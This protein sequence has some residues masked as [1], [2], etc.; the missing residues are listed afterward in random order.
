MSTTHHSAKAAASYSPAWRALI[1][2]TRTHG[3]QYEHAGDWFG[4]AE[5]KYFN[6]QLHGTPIT[7]RYT[8]RT[9]WVASTRFDD[10]TPREYKVQAFDPHW[11]VSTISDDP[12]Y[13][14]AD[15]ALAAMRFIAGAKPE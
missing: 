3:A 2:A 9:Y 14:S 1:D 6:A 15:E 4:V 7:A 10:D 11:G 12:H 8:N 13:P 5:F